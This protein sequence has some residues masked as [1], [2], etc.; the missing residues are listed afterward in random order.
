[1]MKIY[2]KV[3][4]IKESE[5]YQENGIYKGMIGTII[6][7]EIRENKFYVVFIDERYYDKKFEFSDENMELLK[8][9][10]FESIKIEDLE[11]IKNGNASDE[12]ILESLPNNNPKW[13]CKVEDGYVMNL[14]GEKKNKIPYRYDS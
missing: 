14:L 9:D 12:T 4:V 1:M 5:R 3:K 13:W 10:I 6:N 7:P 2:D 11:M 8:D